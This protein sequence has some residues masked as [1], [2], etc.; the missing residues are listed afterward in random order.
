MRR[1]RL[2]VGV[3]V[4]LVA[5]AAPAM[6]KE[7]V[8]ATLDRPVRLDAAAGTTIRVAWRLHHAHGRPFGASGIYLRVSRC[9]RAPLRIRASQARDGGYVARVRMPRGG[10]RKLLVGLEGWRG[11]GERRQRADLFFQF[12]PP[13]HRD[14]P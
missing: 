8:R 9:G 3:L 6:A 13:L 14:C 2:P 10:I 11:A 7:G 4:A 5:L 12:D 1:V